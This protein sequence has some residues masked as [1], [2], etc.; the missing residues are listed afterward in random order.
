MERTNTDK[1]TGYLTAKDLLAVVEPLVKQ[2]DA[3]ETREN[4]VLLRMLDRQIG[5]ALRDV[6]AKKALIPA[7]TGMLR[8]LLAWDEDTGGFYV[9]D[10]NDE[11]VFSTGSGSIKY[12]TIDE[13]V[14]EFAAKPENADFFDKTTSSP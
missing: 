13:L 4:A 10:D 14:N 5:I 3:Y 7:A 2:L 12:K 1:T 9:C 11:F 8:D 6:G